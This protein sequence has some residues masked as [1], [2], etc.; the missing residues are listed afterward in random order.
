MKSLPKLTQTLQ[1]GMTH[2]QVGLG[3]P[4]TAE[5]KNMLDTVVRQKPPAVALLQPDPKSEDDG[6]GATG[7][8]SSVHM[9]HI[10]FFGAVRG[11]YRPGISPDCAAYLGLQR[12]LTDMR[13]LPVQPSR[14]LLY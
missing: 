9:P 5:T 2:L 10:F 1:T 12:P 3:C 6:H 8:C 11:T 14:L 13:S 4:V 7:N